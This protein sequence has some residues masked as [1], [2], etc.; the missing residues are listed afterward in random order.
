MTTTFLLNG[1]EVTATTSPGT[2]VLDWL[3]LHKRRT[4]TKEGCKEG[5]CGACSVMV[6]VLGED[7]AVRYRTMTSCLMPVG[8]L[9]GRHLVTVEG[10]NLPAPGLNPVQ[11]AMV[12]Q[13][14][15]QCGFCT[16]GFIVSMCW[17]MM[18]STD[19]RPSAEGLRH[20]ISGNL[21]RCTGYGSI[22]R[23]IDDL[24]ARFDEGGD[25]HGVWQAADRPAALAAAG[26]LPGY[27]TG[28]ADK[29][30]AI[31]P[32]APDT[33]ERETQPAFFIAGGT[34]LYVQRGEELPDAFVEVLN[35]RDGYEYIDVDGDTVRVGALTTF[36]DF[37]SDARVQAMIPSIKEDMALIASLPIRN[38]ATISGNLINASPI[39]DMTNLMLALGTT[40][41]LR[42]ESGAERE[43]PLEDLYIAYKKLA[44]EPEELVTELRFP[45]V[46]EGDLVSFEKVS[47]RAWLDI[48]TVNSGARLRVEGGVFTYARLSLGGVAAVPLYLKAA[49]AWLVG[50]P[51]DAESARG[52][53]EVAMGEISPISDVRGSAAYKR[54]LARQLLAAHF[55]KLFPDTLS[56]HEVVDPRFATTQEASS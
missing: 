48:A 40:I 3:R 56:L 19:A 22:F 4:G 43:L 54:A 49:S 35:R 28:V 33:T 32:P 27:F 29:L 6:G 23:S 24:V 52:A 47:K 34:D 18:Q 39:G 30:A 38:R 26:L 31:Q 5:D 7:G 13:G 14:G 41:A 15:A 46:R 16:P 21:C 45:V 37:A 25:L 53:I 36:E 20:A 44:R 50:K 8:E 11:E 17:Y 51:L 9:E 2:L 10:V 1:E 55:I 42:S 12:A